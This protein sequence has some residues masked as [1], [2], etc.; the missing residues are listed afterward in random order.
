MKVAFSGSY[1]DTCFLAK[2]APGALRSL[3]KA[4]G[5]ML[6]A[7]IIVRAFLYMHNDERPLKRG[8][9]AVTSGRTRASRR[10]GNQAD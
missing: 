2:L 5:F 6:S 10:E 9:G 3:A 4:A 1:Y 8:F 7:L